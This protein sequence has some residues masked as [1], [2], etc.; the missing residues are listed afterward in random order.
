MTTV[1]QNK[2]RLQ[3]DRAVSGNGNTAQSLINETSVAIIIIVSLWEAS[4]VALYKVTPLDKQIGPLSSILHV[5]LKV[6]KNQK[7]SHVI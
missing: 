6:E 7:N 4:S 5:T 3:L 1:Q 2:W